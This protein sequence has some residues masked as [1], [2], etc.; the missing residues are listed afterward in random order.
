MWSTFTYWQKR[1][2]IALIVLTPV[3]FYSSCSKMSLTTLDRSV[4][5]VPAKE[6]RTMVRP[7]NKEIINQPVVSKPVIN[8][9][10]NQEDDCSVVPKEQRKLCEHI[11]SRIS[12]DDVIVTQEQLEATE[13]R[14]QE[15]LQQS[16]PQERAI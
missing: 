6:W 15:M 3:M 7:E 9:T 10:V 4:H 13:A 16:L 1:I 5:N 12:K 14:T 2:T 8:A 11:A